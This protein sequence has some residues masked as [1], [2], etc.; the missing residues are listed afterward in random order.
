[1][2]HLNQQRI[3]PK[4]FE[5][6]IES[7]NIRLF[8]LQNAH[9]AT[10]QIMNHG[11]KLV[12]LYVPDAQGMLRD[13]VIGHDSLEEYLN[14]EETYFGAI[15]GRYANRIAEGRFALD[16][17]S[18]T[19][20]VNNGS[21]CL[22]GGLR[23]FNAVAWDAEQLSE[24]SL[25]LHYLSPDGEE[26]FPGNLDICVT[27]TLTDDHE[28]AI[29]YEA[30]TDKP[31][32]LNL[33]HHAYFNL[34]GN[35]D[36]SILDH[37]LQIHAAEYLPTD[38]TAI[39]LG[40]PEPVA[41]TPMDFTEPTAIGLR[42][43]EPTD[44]LRWARGYDHTYILNKPLGQLGP[45]AQVT[46]PQSGIVMTVYTD[47]PGVQL[48]TGNWMSGNMHGKHDARYPARAAFCLETQHYP[49][50]PNH[51]EYPSTRLNPG[52]TFGSTTVYAF[53]TANQSIPK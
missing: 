36:T 10:A 12:S 1:M 11:G 50:S 8:T 46:S 4:R 51:P 18:Y 42:I 13:V 43:N 7:K 5:G 53:S 2:N 38:D 41:G 25:R 26:G 17:K 27:Y 48:Y 30:V 9:G 6:V 44:Q 40:K 3:D 47:Q 14:S 32:V 15:C 22:H 20:P 52:E 23:G 35:G 28:L 31:T 37:I 45:A 19:L 33:T 29:E 24:R 34:S 21:N 39:P 16:G 49:D